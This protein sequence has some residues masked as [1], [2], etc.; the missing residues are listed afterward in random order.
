MLGRLQTKLTKDAILA[1]IQN[2]QRLA[3]IAHKLG[4]MKCL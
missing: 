3:V 4:L 1:A 2:L